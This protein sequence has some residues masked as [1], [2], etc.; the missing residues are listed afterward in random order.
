MNNYEYIIAS[1]PDFRQDDR[2]VPDADAVIEDIKSQLGSG[3]MVLLDTLLKGWD[4]ESLDRDFYLKSTA[5]RNA[6]IRGW[7]SFDLAVRNEKVRFLNRELGREADTDVMVL[8]EDGQPQEGTYAQDALAQKDILSRERALDTLMWNKAE[9]L[10]LMHVFDMDVILATVAK[11]KIT[12]RWSKLDP[13][14]GKEMF[15]RLVNELRNNR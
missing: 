9:E 2:N 8:S 7:F 11:L 15:R 4:A 12:D 3:D 1:L 10:T 13:E 6:F 5:S 14:T